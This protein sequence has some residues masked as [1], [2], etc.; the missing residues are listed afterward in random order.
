MNRIW[1]YFKREARSLRDTYFF[2]RLIHYEKNGY[3]FNEP[4]VTSA[5]EISY[6]SL[7][8]RSQVKK[9]I[10]VL[11]VLGFIER[12]IIRQKRNNDQIGYKSI[13]YYRIKRLSDELIE[14]INKNKLNAVFESEIRSYR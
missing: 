6:R 4:F 5:K 3:N 11:V 12:V 1:M 7:L 2:I 9:Y 8:S 10:K 13:A 14:E